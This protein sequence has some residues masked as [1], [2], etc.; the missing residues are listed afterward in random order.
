MQSENIVGQKKRMYPWKHRDAIH[1]SYKS[2]VAYIAI[3]VSDRSTSATKDA[4]T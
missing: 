4:G 2:R 1:Q 3:L